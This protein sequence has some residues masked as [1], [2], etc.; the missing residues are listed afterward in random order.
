[1]ISWVLLRVTS[2]WEGR[3]ELFW[4]EPLVVCA[5]RSRFVVIVAN[6]GH[7]KVDCPLVKFRPSHAVYGS[8]TKGVGLV[9]RLPP[10]VAPEGL[11][12]RVRDSSAGR[13]DA[14][15]E[16][17]HDAFESMVGSERKVPVTI[18]RN[19]M[20]FHSFIRT[21]VLPWSSESDTGGF[22]TVRGI[23]LKAMLVPV[24]EVML[25]CD[26][27]QGEAETRRGDTC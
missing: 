8:Q 22:V 1:M 5:V 9:A 21:G 27:F 4:M 16:F 19:T 3:V 10:A 18:L 24:H 7:W 12:W 2:H 23:N 26:L 20:V 6:E 25:H 11:G 13:L 17:I 15:R 14:Y